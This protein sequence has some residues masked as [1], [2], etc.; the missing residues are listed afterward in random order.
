MAAETGE[1]GGW[2]VFRCWTASG[3]EVRK[4]IFIE[5]GGDYG[6]GDEGLVV[7]VVRDVGVV[8]AGVGEEG[9]GL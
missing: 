9:G 6:V 7:A 4:I 3:S 2:G 8:E 5:F 1:S